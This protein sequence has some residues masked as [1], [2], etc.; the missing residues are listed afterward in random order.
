MK[1]SNGSHLAYCTN[2]HRG[3]SWS[4][5]F[6]SLESYVLQV[7]EKVS[8]DDPFAIGLRLGAEAARELADPDKLFSFQ[9]WLEKR[10]CYVFTINGFPLREL[11]RYPGKRGGVPP[12]LDHSGS[13]RVHPAAFRIAGETPFLPEPKAVSAP[14]RLFLRNSFPT[15]PSQRF[16]FKT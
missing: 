14:P 11:S 15:S 2:V 7:R 12:R 5:T 6:D 13:P 9:Q 16:F 3:N 8:P 1:L 4:E 10:D